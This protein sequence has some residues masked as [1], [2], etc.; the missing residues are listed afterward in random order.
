MTRPASLVIALVVLPLAGCAYYNGMWSA[1]R[2]AREARRQEAKGLDGEAKLS[3]ARAA[4]RAE[5]VI[6]RHPRSRWADDAL[7]LQGEG[8]ARSGACEAAAGPLRRAL[9]VVG[10]DALRERA[11]LVAAECMLHRGA[12]GDVERLLAPVFASRNSQRRSAAEYLAGRAALERGDPATAAARFARSA[13]PEAS[14][15]RIRALLAAGRL[16]QAAALVDSAARR[17]QNE[18]AWSAVLD[19]FG[20]TAGATAAADALDRLLARGHVS[21]GG[22]ARLLV[23][24]GDRLRAQRTFDRAATRYAVVAAL[25][26]DSVEAGRARVRSVLVQAAQAERPS[27]LDS[28]AARLQRASAGLGGATQLEA[29]AV[30]SQIALIRGEDTSEVSAFRAAELARDSLAAP[31]LAAALFLRFAEQYPASLFAPKALIAAGQLRPDALDSVG[32]VLRSSYVASPYTLAFQGAPSPAFRTLEDS[33][34]IALG[35][36]RPSAAAFAA[37]AHHVAAPRP[38]PRGPQLEPPPTEPPAARARPPAPPGER[39][40]ARVRRPGE[41]PPTRPEERP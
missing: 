6:V 13:L 2:L 28:I 33:L 19:E 11:A 35:V 16:D 29:R 25:V 12:R 5:S 4:V 34:A 32:T 27:D 38:G 39:R 30:Q 37:A 8:L 20:R 15:A 1:E 14:T 7:V 40:P 24:D 26:P 3:W 31:A 10:D 23:A 41:K 17:D 18:A 36:A 22:R 9:A 21:I